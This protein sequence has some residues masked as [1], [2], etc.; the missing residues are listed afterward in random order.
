MAP[1]RT[2]ASA[3][4]PPSRSIGTTS[5][6]EMSSR[7]HP[8]TASAVET[9]ASRTGSAVCRLCIVMAPSSGSKGDVHAPDPLA[10]RGLGQEVGRREVVVLARLVQ[11][12]VQAAVARPRMEVVAGNGEAHRAGIDL[13]RPGGRRVIGNRDFA[14]LDVVGILDV[15]RLAPQDVGNGGS[16]VGERRLRIVPPLAV[17]QAA[18][19]LLR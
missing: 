19:K 18:A 11:L 5:G 17:V 10:D 6:L 3:D 1:A 7:W 16:L 8:S 2:V 4:A 13:L 15:A 14:Q 12:G 9:S